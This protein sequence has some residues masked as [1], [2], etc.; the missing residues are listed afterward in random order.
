M[1]MKKIPEDQSTLIN[2]MRYILYMSEEVVENFV[3]SI[4]V[5]IFVCC[6]IDKWLMK[7]RIIPSIN[8]VYFKLH[9]K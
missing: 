8:I 5:P 9:M 4:I 1:K 6:Q 7:I 3:T 2:I